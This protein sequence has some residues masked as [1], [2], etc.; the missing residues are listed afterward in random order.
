M[1]P[2]PATASTH[3]ATHFPTALARLGSVRLRQGS[4]I[5]LL[6]FT[7]DGKALMSLGGDQ[8]MRLW[9]VDTGKELRRFERKGQT[10]NAG[11]GGRYFKGGMAALPPM[12]LMGDVRNGDGPSFTVAVSADAKLLALVDPHN[13]VLI[14]NTQ[15]GK[16]VHKVELREQSGH[17]IALSPDGKLLAIGENNGEERIVRVWDLANN[18]ELPSLQV[19]RQRVVTRLLFAADG[20]QLAGISGAQVRLR[21]VTLGKPTRLYEGH[22]AQVLAI[23]FSA[24]GQ[25]LAS[26]AGDG[27]LRVWETTSEEEVKKFTINDAQ[28]TAVVLTP[29]G[30]TLIAASSNNAANVVHVWD[31]ISG[32][33]RHLLE[34]YKAARAGPGCH[35]RWQDP[36]LG[37][38]GGRHSPVEHGYRPG[39]GQRQAERPRG[40]LWFAARRPYRG[41]VG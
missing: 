14:F 30:N 6:H 35:A 12:I 36:C 31:L 5:C 41:G 22:E 39:N 37:K 19:G 1:I 8:G 28:F 9:N 20:K 38:H 26:A 40:S 18:K 4:E 3:R 29:D 34:G 25:K 32:Q 15:S 10:V 2:N 27:T 11:F 33:E 17:P 24:D 21:D 16:Q 23:A 7:P 13:Q